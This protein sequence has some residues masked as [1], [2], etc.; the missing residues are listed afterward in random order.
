MKI[1]IQ[2]SFLIK[3]SFKNS[4]AKSKRAVQI[5]NY[6]TLDPCYIQP[7]IRKI[8]PTNKKNV[9]KSTKFIIR[10]KLQLFQLFCIENQIEIHFWLD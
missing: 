5:H 9:P 4:A 1:K 8:N 2:L 10:K 6:H 3:I 7:D